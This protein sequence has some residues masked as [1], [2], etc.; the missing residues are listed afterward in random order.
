MSCKD[1]P[2]WKPVGM[3]LYCPHCVTPNK[4]NGKPLTAKQ[5]VRVAEAGKGVRIDDLSGNA[6]SIIRLRIRERDQYQCKSCGIAVRVG[7]VDH[8]KPLEQSGSNADDNLQLMCHPCH[9]DKTNRDRGFKVRH[10]TGVDGMPQGS[11]HH[12]N[13]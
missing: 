10:H 3:E 9:V 1:H 11:D 12:W 4:R 8:I 13:R 2:E 6:W 5:R 7:V